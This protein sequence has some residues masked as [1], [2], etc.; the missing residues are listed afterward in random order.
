MHH[1][2]WTDA[3]QLFSD[4]L[5]VSEEDDRAH[6]GL[7]EA[8]WNR[9]QQQE[10]IEHMEHAVKLSAN[11]PRLVGRLGEM[12]LAND[13]LDDARQQSEIALRSER[14]S[15]EIWTLHG[16]CLKQSG[17]S[18]EA[19]AAYHRALALQPDYVDAKLRV[20][21]LYLEDFQYDRLLATLDQIDSGGGNAATPA[22][23][24]MLRGIAMRNLGRPELAS[25][26]FNRAA[27]SDPQLAEPYLQIAA[28]HLENARPDL[29]GDAVDSAMQ[30]NPTLV[31]ESGWARFLSNPGQWVAEDPLAIP[32]LK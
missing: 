26:H 13:R 20:A 4:A 27:T 3:E 30:R 25:R 7:A 22:R 2:R 24:H 18:E 17:K 14:N 1:G 23:V 28:I 19:L 32:T 11:D 31:N 21:E 16:D 15:A 8:Y 12:Y 29:A 9:D 5:N 6:R 10:A